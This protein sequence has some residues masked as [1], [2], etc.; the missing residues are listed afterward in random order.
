MKTLLR[1]AL[2]LALVALAP[3]AGI[4]ADATGMM[5]SSIQ[6]GGYARRV[7][8]GVGKSVMIAL[9]RDAKEV[10][11]ADPKIANAVVRSARSAYLIGAAIGQTTVLFLDA[12]GGQILSLDVNVGRDLG[13]IQDTIGRT[14]GRGSVAV[15]AIG[16]AVVLSGAVAS[17]ADATTAAA[18]A[19]RYVGDPAKVVNSLTIRDRDQ[20]MLKV[21]VA[22]VQRNIIKQLGVDLS[23][24]NW[25]LGTAV[26]GPSTAP[27]FNFFTNNPFPVNSQAPTGNY[28]VG[29]SQPGGGQFSATVRALEQY[30]VFRTLAEP[31]LTA[32]SG[33]SAKF[34]AGG[35]FPIPTGQTCDQTGSCI[36]T[37]EYKQFGVSL[38]FTPVVL[39]EG[40][41]SLKVSTEVSEIS[42]DV[43]VQL[44]R[45]QVPGLRVRR[46][47]STVEL[48]SG[49]SLVMAGLIKNQTRQALSG[50]P[51]LMNVP[52]LGALFKSRDYQREETELAI[53]VTPY[54][55]RSVARSELARPDDGFADASDPSSILLGRL[56]RLYGI[57]GKIDPTTLHGSYGF[58]ID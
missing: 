30:G 39:S 43:S 57:P 52:V 22:E 36:I 45:I 7:D 27:P 4:A 42:N 8:L 49:G 2:A 12:N 24:S 54:L 10:F 11:V 23:A 20:V 18:I 50:T 16:D 3:L 21:T 31:T 9:P 33:E 15:Q 14:L 44:Q 32:I 56:N 46:A 35:E 19:A 1:P 37:I 6:D 41:I 13:T 55:A 38:N 5:R 28:G 26:L 48:P 29:W 47:D 25:A 53:F 40:R 58:I 17:A 51:G 34:L